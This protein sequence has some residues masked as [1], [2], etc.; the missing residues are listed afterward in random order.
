MTVKRTVQ[1]LEYP[2]EFSTGERLI[3]EE[4]QCC[5]YQTEREE[6]IPR[7]PPSP[8]PSSDSSNSYSDSS[9]SYS[10]SSDSSSSYSS[11]SDSGGGGAGGSW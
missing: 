1:T 9:S 5:E 2:S 10:N 11:S 7:L 6:I 8:P 4:C 3:T